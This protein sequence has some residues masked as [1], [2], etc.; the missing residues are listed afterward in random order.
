[1]EELIEL[2]KDKSGCIIMETMPDPR[3]GFKS[4]HAIPISQ[5]GKVYIGRGHDN[6]IRVTDISVSRSHAV[7][8]IKNGSVYL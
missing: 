4:V 8:Q 1:V 6:D 5:N 7:I 2:P 3:T